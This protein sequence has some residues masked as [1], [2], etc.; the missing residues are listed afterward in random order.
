MLTYAQLFHPPFPY[1]TK[2]RAFPS[3]RS[4]IYQGDA[5]GLRTLYRRSEASAEVSPGR[6][7]GTDQSLTVAR[8][9]LREF[10]KASAR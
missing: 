9:W 5:Y 10:Q 6:K 1:L 7:A 2:T 8:P 3:A 4:S